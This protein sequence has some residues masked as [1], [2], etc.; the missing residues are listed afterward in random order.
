MWHYC[1]Q[2]KCIQ[3]FGG[4]LEEKR[5]LGK[6]SLSLEDNIKVDKINKVGWFG[7]EQ[8]GSGWKWL[9]LTNTVMILLL[10]QN[11]ENFLNS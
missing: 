7:L 10:P 8:S 9:L 2:G 1:G 4:E 11:A 3:G 5:L 6:R